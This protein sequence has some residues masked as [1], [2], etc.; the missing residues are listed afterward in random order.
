MEM[1]I[2]RHC[3]V[4][5]GKTTHAGGNGNHNPVP[6][7]LFMSIVLLLL[8][9]L[10]CSTAYGEDRKDTMEKE[11]Q[12]LFDYLKNA[13]C[14]F[15]RNGKWYDAEEAVKHINKKY[16]Y[17]LKHGA[18]NSTEQ[19]IE[20]AASKSSMSGKFYMVKCGAS[21]PIKSS[22][23]FKSELTRYRETTSGNH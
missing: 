11:I 13:G 14:E 2:T 1:D 7:L 18:V 15:N 20:Q 19:F 12:H 21:E 16:Q 4:A 10:L 17:L 5:L 8:A 22:V 23:W 3:F 9:L 6:N